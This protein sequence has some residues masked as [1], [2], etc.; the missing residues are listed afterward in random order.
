M[1]VIEA[2]RVTSGEWRARGEEEPAR[3]RRYEITA[4]TPQGAIRV[5][6]RPCAPGAQ[7]N[8]ARP[9]FRPPRREGPI[10]EGKNLPRASRAH[11]QRHFGRRV[12]RALACAPVIVLTFARTA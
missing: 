8:L 1:G 6:I 9:V 10:R 5:E 12:A 11:L 7:P 2:W 4:S 3:C